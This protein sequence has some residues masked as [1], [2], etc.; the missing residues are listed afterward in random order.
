MEIRTRSSL[1]IETNIKI[2]TRPQQNIKVSGDSM[3]IV[4]LGIFFPEHQEYPLSVSSSPALPACS[5]F[6]GGIPVDPG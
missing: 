2:N 4:T 3:N 6:F 5:S 1:F